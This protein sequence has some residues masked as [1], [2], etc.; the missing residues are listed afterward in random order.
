MPYVP[1]FNPQV[2]GPGR[3][4]QFS[5]VA[6]LPNTVLK[7]SDAGGRDFSDAFANDI[8]DLDCDI[9]GMMHLRP[10]HVKLGDGKTVDVSSIFEVRLS[11]TM[12]YG[13]IDESGLTLYDIPWIV[14]PKIPLPPKP[15]VPPD[16]VPSDYPASFP[17]PPHKTPTPT[18]PDDA[19]PSDPSVQPKDQSCENSHTHSTNPNALYFSMQKGGTLPADQ[20][21]FWQVA[22]WWP[23]THEGTYESSDSQS[24][25]T[26]WAEQFE[27][28]AWYWLVKQCKAVL[29]KSVRVHITDAAQSL[30]AGLYVWPDS[31]VWTDGDVNNVD[32]RLEVLEPSMSAN[33]P[34]TLQESQD[35]AKGTWQNI[36]VSNATAG[37]TLNWTAAIASDTTPGKVLQL[38]AASGSI[39]G[40]GSNTITL[41][42]SSIPA[43]GS[44]VAHVTISGNG[45]P[46]TIDVEVDILITPTAIAHYWN[47]YSDGGNYNNWGNGVLGWDNTNQWW[48]SVGNMTLTKAGTLTIWET[49]D[50]NYSS[51]VSFT[52]ASNG[53]IVGIWGPYNSQM[54]P[55]RLWKV[56]FQQT[57][58]P[59]PP[60]TRP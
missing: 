9:N 8:Q 51:T 53:Y 48:G 14:N 49:G 10:G 27:M 30:D 37:T 47:K 29:V 17:K 16:Q 18:P 22:G 54:T 13:V 36:T 32:I 52:L 23:I 59:P 55:G 11:G 6:G 58:P 40:V 41:S 15:Y 42:F 39:V 25:P 46:D 57:N 26:G 45:V 3:L 43:S 31:L 35:A 44:Y 19:P 34:V 20:Y 7:K 21:W 38:S 4:R 24:A 5:G 1:P 33:T 56:W 28:Q 2:I 60:I 12:Q 50:G